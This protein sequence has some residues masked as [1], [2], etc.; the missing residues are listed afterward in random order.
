M[1]TIENARFSHI[2]STAIRG[3]WVKPI[4]DA[5]LDPIYT[6]A[7]ELSIPFETILKKRMCGID[8]KSPEEMISNPLLNKNNHMISVQILLILFKKIIK[9]GRY[10]TMNDKGD[11]VTE[12]DYKKIIQ[13]QLVVAEEVSQ[14]HL[15]GFDSNHFLYS[16]YHLSYQRNLANEFLRM[17]YMMEKLC[18]DLLALE[19]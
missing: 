17:Y 6:L 12:N 4:V 10:E 18:R 15:K 7:R 13:L 3:I 2:G 19:A 16:A 11:E 14:K 5:E 8:P 9:Y 1:L